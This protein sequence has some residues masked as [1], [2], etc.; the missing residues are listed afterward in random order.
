MYVGVVSIF[1]ELFSNFVATSLVGAAV[2]RG[3]M[4][5]A[6]EDLRRFTDDRHRSVDDEPA[7]SVSRPSAVPIGSNAISATTLNRKM[8]VTASP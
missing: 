4:S 7:D 8:V 5:V 6:V 1:P 2:E 3:L